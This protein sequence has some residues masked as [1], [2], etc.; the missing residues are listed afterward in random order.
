MNIIKAIFETRSVQEI[1]DLQLLYLFL[2]YEFYTLDGDEF[3]NH[4]VVLNI[5]KTVTSLIVLFIKKARSITQGK[6]STFH[7]D[8]FLPPKEKSEALKSDLGLPPN[9]IIKWWAK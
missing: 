9:S 2:D 5:I 6:T 1:T 4:K 7:G 8:I 3:Q